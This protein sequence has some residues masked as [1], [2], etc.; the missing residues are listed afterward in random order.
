[1]AKKQPLGKG[2]SFRKMVSLGQKIKWLKHAKSDSTI[3]LYF[4]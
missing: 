2:Y 4:F 3:T 1:M